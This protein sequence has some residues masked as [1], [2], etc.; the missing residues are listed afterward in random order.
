MNAKTREKLS[1]IFKE[2]NKKLAH[3]LGIDIDWQ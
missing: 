2:P 1:E 3:L